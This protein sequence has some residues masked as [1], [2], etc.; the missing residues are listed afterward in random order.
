MLV[1]NL[2]S[3]IY[4]KVWN[5]SLDWKCDIWVINCC[6]CSLCTKSYNWV[7]L[8][9]SFNYSFSKNNKK[10]QIK[11]FMVR[12][13]IVS[14]YKLENL[15]KMETTHIQSLI[16]SNISIVLYIWVQRYVKF[17]ISNGNSQEISHITNCIKLWPRQYEPLHYT[18]DD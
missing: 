1:T 8:Y 3:N 4:F 14:K 18:R 12:S 13:S 2:L 6:E 7:K 16:V 5:F 17:L 10:I 9:I 11:K 15:S